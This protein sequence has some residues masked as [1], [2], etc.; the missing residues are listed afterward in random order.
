MMVLFLFFFADFTYQPQT[1]RWLDYTRSGQLTPTRHVVMEHT[2]PVGDYKDGGVPKIFDNTGRFLYEMNEAAGAWFIMGGI[3]G[4]DD[5]F[6]YQKHPERSDQTQNTFHLWHPQY[7]DREILVNGK[8]L[9]ANREPK[10]IQKSKQGKRI[11]VLSLDWTGANNKPYYHLEVIELKGSLQDVFGANELPLATYLD[12]RIDARESTMVGE[13]AYLHG[14]L[15]GKEFQAIDLSTFGPGIPINEVELALPAI[16]YHFGAGMVAYS[17]YWDGSPASV[18]EGLSDTTPRFVLAESDKERPGYQ[19]LKLFLG[20]FTGDLVHREGGFLYARS[21]DRFYAYDLTSDI[22]SVFRAATTSEPW[23]SVNN[24]Q[25]VTVTTARYEVKNQ[26]SS[27]QA[28]RAN[29]PELLIQV[30]AKPFQKPM[31]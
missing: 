15:G 27:L 11:G 7:G 17:S 8:S 10:F 26:V 3:A 23:S 24:E 9:A 4:D 18:L 2:G 21:A 20:A 6:L 22:L 25:S 1:G 28:F 14:Q 19:A 30:N 5:L 29:R 16:S 12:A 13:V 31:E